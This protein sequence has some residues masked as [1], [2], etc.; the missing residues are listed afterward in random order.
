M[1]DLQNRVELMY[2]FVHNEIHRFIGVD[3]V[4]KLNSR[5]K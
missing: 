4:G 2:E 5:K 1:S 3:I